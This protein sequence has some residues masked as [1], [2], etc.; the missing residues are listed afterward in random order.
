MIISTDAQ[1]AFDKI[2]HTSMIK[3]KKNSPESKY[4]R[5]ILQHNKGHTQQTHRKHSQL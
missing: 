5:K 4:P 1:K 3:K 2:H